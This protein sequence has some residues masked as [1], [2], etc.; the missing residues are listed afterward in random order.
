[1]I[2][3]A[4]NNGSLYK[5]AQKLGHHNDPFD[6]RLLSQSLEESMPIISVDT[7][8]AIDHQIA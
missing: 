3:V 6:R 1:M 4:I 5:S 8:F 7:K 2:N